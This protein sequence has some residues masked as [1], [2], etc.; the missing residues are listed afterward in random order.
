MFHPP[1]FHP[2]RPGLVA[3][4]RIDPAGLAGPTRG[5]ARGPRWRAS[6][7][8]WYVPAY[9]DPTVVE[10]RIVEA[11]ACLLPYGG[12]TG[13]AA[14]RWQHAPWF[15][16]LGADGVTPR[17]VTLA[18]GMFHG[19]SQPGITMSEERC[20][21][22]DLTEVDGLRVTTAVRSAT[23]EM[24]YAADE[25]SAAVVLDMAAYSDL[26]SISEAAAFADEL[27]GW[28]GIPQCRAALP[29]AD[30]NSWSVRE[31][32]M[33]LVWEV[34]AG[35][36]RPLTNRPVFDRAG[37]LLGVPDLLDPVAGV[38]GEYD[39]AVHLAGR[40]RARDVRREHLFRSVGL[41]YVVMLAPDFSDIDGF[42]SR[43]HATYAR[44]A[45]AAE[46][47]RAWTIEPPPWWTP[48]VTVDQRRALD[49]SMRSRLLRHRLRTGGLPGTPRR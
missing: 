5:Q 27:N 42:V 15:D 32:L 16:G 49:P 24:R 18:T 28:T 17:P 47:T 39:G 13:W 14:L 1:P 37:R 21:P 23:F 9:L 2:N 31:S 25:R 36:P 38:V 6:A 40:Q 22:E 4:V 34:D 33:R 7:H 41:E 20:R 43:L 8:G 10:Q 12:V 19:R 48:T 44:A 30:E 26:V 11:A 3:P 46:S 45:H 35:K 29:L